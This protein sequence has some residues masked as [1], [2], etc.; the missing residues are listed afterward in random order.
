MAHQAGA[1]P[2]FPS[3]K[4]QGIFLLPSGWDVSPLQGYPQ[5]KFAGTDLYTWVERS[6][7]RVKYLAQEHNTMSSTRAQT[8]MFNLET[9]ILTMGRLR[10]HNPLGGN[11]KIL[12]V[13]NG[14]TQIG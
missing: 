7:M 6:A 10:L 1:Y 4:R 13:F 12:L 3:M 14:H 9:S 5:H 8:W 11:F 2:G